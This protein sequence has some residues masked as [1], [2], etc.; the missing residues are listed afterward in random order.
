MRSLLCWGE[1][2]TVPS[3]ESVQEG[4][5]TG[6]AMRVR[7]GGVVR[8][9]RVQVV[10]IFLALVLLTFASPPQHPSCCVAPFTGKPVMARRERLD[11]LTV[12]QSARYRKLKLRFMYQRILIL[13]CED[14]IQV[15]S[16]DCHVG[17]PIV[18]VLGKL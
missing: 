5:P 1:L 16:K 8:I 17:M 11:S 2:P 12:S 4:N 9:V 3:E 15:H 10:R 6:R 7:M 13:I 14:E 18:L